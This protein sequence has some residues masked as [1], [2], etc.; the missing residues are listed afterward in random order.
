MK[1][2]KE[3]REKM[4]RNPRSYDELVG[5][6]DLITFLRNCFE[7]KIYNIA[8]FLGCTEG[9]IRRAL[10]HEY[11]M[12]LLYDEKMR[13]MEDTWQITPVVDNAKLARKYYV[14]HWAECLLIS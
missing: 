13:I 12:Y 11:N 7:M 14:M 8:G 6:A 2:L 5:P 3:F 9:E 10:D 4:G 1:L